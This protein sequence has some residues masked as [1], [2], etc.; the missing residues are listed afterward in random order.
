MRVTPGTKLTPLFVDF[1]TFWSKDFTL[2]K[3]PTGDYIRDDR[4]KV[5]CVSAKLGKGKTRSFTNMAKFKA[6]LA[7]LDP[8]KI[9]VVGHNLYFDGLIL[10]EHCDF[11]P[12]AWHCTMSMSR[13][14]WRNTC[15]HGLNPLAHRLGLQGK[16]KKAA[17]ESTK[18]KVTLTKLE[19]SNLC[20]YCNDDVEDTAAAYCMMLPYMP[21]IEMEIISH[22][23]RCFV[24]PLLEIDGALLEEAIDE[25]FARREEL[26]ARVEDLIRKV[27]PEVGELHKALTSRTKF[28]R[29]LESL[30]VEVPM[31]ISPRTGKPTYALASKDP[32]Y[33]ALCDSDDPMVALLCETRGEFTSNQTS[34][35]AQRLLSATKGGATLPVMYLYCG[36]HT[37]RW[38]ASGKMNLQNLQRGSKLRKAILAPEGYHLMVGDSA[39]IEARFTGWIAGQNDLTEA[40]RQGR[41]VYSEFATDAFG[42][43]VEKCNEQEMERFV[44]K[45]CILGLGF[46]MGWKKLLTTLFLGG[47]DLPAHRIQAIHTLYRSKYDQIVRLWSKLDMVLASMAA[48]GSGTIELANG[49]LVLE[50]EPDKIWMPNGLALHYPGLRNKFDEEGRHTGYEFLFVKG[51]RADGTP[52]MFWKNV[53]GGLLTENIV[54]CLARIAVSEQIV[55]VARRYRVVMTTHDEMVTLVKADKKSLAAGEKFMTKV[56]AT[57]PWWAQSLPISSEVKHAPNYSK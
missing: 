41:D 1:E 48:G 54:Q 14:L 44:G 15:A 32:E 19:L 16:V 37:M 22:T 11:V 55:T 27:C 31:K 9:V 39:Q 12:A 49:E 52:I 40:F 4:F 10:T 43:H 3:I 30:G 46:G 50:Y 8:D 35:R 20:E 38:S 7:K 53:Y 36:A 28:V 23:V 21:E 2:K 25:V 29:I 45:T 13:G 47:V 34:T 6:W 18:D 56:M 42:Y 17:L 24:E 26:L 51:A 5:H 33:M 57:P